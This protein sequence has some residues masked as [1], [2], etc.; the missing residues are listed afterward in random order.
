[1]SLARGDPDSPGRQAWS[2]DRLVL[3]VA[4]ARPDGW[5][6]R[7]RAGNG[8]AWPGTAEVPVTADR[9][10]LVLPLRAEP[11]PAFADVIADNLHADTP[12]GGDAS[13]GSLRLH[14]DFSPEA[15]S[16]A[17]A[18]E[19]SL[20]A[21]AI[22]PPSGI[23]RPLGPRI[24]SLEMDGAL[25]G[26]VPVGRTLA[27]QAAAWRDG[28]GSLEV[29]HLALVW[30]PLDLTASATLALDDQLQPMGAGSARW[31]VTRR[32][33]TPWRRMARSAGQPRPRPRPCCR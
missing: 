19:F 15:Q 3:R 13:V 1:M 7:P 32:R 22:S 2:A 11:W 27:E 4:L 25:N 9:L 30:G 16:G 14:L 26:P 20:R 33:S 10:R 18:L 21:E 23:V 6:S 12:I 17:P 24:A 5:K 29:R 28:G 8:C 31:W